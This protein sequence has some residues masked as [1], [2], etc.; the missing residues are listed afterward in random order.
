MDFK[1]IRENEKKFNG[2]VEDVFTRVGKNMLKE[3]KENKE[4]ENPKLNK[5]KMETLA[6][7][8]FTMQLATSMY[9]TKK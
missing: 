8:I 2:Y 6:N 7:Y 1:E 9:S 4:A 5:E 3:Y